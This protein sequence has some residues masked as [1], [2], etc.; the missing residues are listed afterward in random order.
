MT[1]HRPVAASAAS[2]AC[3]T[4]CANRR[5]PA[6]VTYCLPLVGGLPAHAGNN[7]P[8]PGA[9]P[10][11]AGMMARHVWGRGLPW[12]VALSAGTACPA[13]T[14]LGCSPSRCARGWQASWLRGARYMGVAARPLTLGG[15]G[16][17]PAETVLHWAHMQRPLHPKSCGTV[18][19]LHTVSTGVSIDAG[20][21]NARLAASLCIARLEGRSHAQ[22][23]LFAGGPPVPISWAWR[24]CRPTAGRGGGGGAPLS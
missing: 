21:S 14:G 5:S 13:G 15:G 20:V 1:L 10:S 9:S 24:L 16:V 23:C 6:L 2:H 3:C 7:L 22:G 12:T 4:G 19:V 11:S 18:K 8:P 17:V